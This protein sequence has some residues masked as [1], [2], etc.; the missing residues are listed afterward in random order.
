MIKKDAEYATL[1]D[2]A[3]ISQG[4]LDIELKSLPG[5]KVRIKKITIGEIADIMKVAK[6]S[7]LDQA[8]WMTFRGLINPKLSVEEIRKWPAS[9]LVE[10][11]IEIGKFSGLDKESMEKTTNLFTTES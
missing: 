2:L 5:K 10:I 4:E 7:T 9:V 3:A 11:S 6:E 1:S 8:I